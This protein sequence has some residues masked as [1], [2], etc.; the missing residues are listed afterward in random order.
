[1]S[2][3]KNI[4]LRFKALHQILYNLNKKNMGILVAFC[5]IKW[6]KHYV[7]ETYVSR[8]EMFDGID[9][10]K[11]FAYFQLICNFDEIKYKKQIENFTGKLVHPNTNS[12]FSSV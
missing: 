9:F 4:Q 12:L 10:M 7:V 6:S 1:M 5:S 3:N 2:Q 11:D 8:C